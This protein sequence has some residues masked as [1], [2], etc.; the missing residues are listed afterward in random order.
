MSPSDPQFPR[1]LSEGQDAAA[2]LI[3]RALAEP[4][5]GPSEQRSWRKLRGRSTGSHVRW[6]LPAVACAISIVAL[7][8]GWRQPS[9][10]LSVGPDV[11]SS[12]SV[13]P[14]PVALLPSRDPERAETPAVPSARPKTLTPRPAR[15]SDSAECSR[16][17]KAG[18]YDAA[19]DCYG[20]AARGSSM[21]AELA[22]YEKARLEARALGKSSSALATLDDH[23]R[24]FPAGVL[25]TEVELTRIELLSQ[26]GRRGEALLAIERGLNGALGRERSGDLQ[27]LRAELLGADGNCAAAGEAMRLASRAGVHPS[28]LEAAERRCPPPAPQAPA[29]EP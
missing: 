10:T 23:A 8:I 20:R 22:L 26:L 1:R 17:A 4:L 27:V 6:A 14:P 18:Q 28:R 12:T 16:Q 3:A 21:N 2:A 19:V 25:T 24:R 5:P 29:D 7:A 15:D 9:S 13:A 11:W